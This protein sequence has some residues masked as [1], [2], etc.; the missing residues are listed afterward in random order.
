MARIASILRALATAFWRDQKSLGSVATNNFF[1]FTLF[2]LRQAAGF[3]ML[4]LGVVLLL[5]LS[6]DPLRRVPRDRLAL[7]PLTSRERLLLRIASPWLNPLTW[8]M[9][10]LSVW[11]GQWVISPGLWALFG[12]FFIAGFLLPAI[13]SAAPLKVLSRI[14]PALPGTFGPLIRKNLREILSTLDFYTALAL[15]LSSLAFRLLHPGVPPE[16]RMACSM[17][18]V[19]ALSSFAQCLFG[20]EGDGLTR[21]RLMPVRGWQV[22]A[23][24]GAAF[25]LVVAVLT[26]PQSPVAGLSAGMIALAVGHYP[27]VTM[28]RLQHRWRFTSGAALGNGLIQVAAMTMAAAAAFRITPLVLIPCA[29]VYAGSTWWYGRA[30][31]RGD[32]ADEQ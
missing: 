10:A 26:V 28:P 5:P 15:S 17:L 29:A 21:Y 22:L 9:A 24:K 30:L 6:A 23:S 20:L 18:I 7:W 13:P 1:L 27:S 4:L 19:L 12:V 3:P 8:L 14:L 32:A 25:L 31:T 16:V 2:F 11:A